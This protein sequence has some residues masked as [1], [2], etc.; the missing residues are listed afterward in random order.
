[1]D[2]MKFMVQGSEE[3]PYLVT[4]EREETN[5][6][7]YCTCAAGARGQYCKHRFR[8][9]SGNPEDLIEPDFPRLRL[10]VD[11]LAGT[12]IEAA[13]RVLAKAEDSFEK[14]KAD[15]AKAKKSLAEAMRR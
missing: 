15:L 14:A 2:Q 1:M 9:L 11:W 5:L 8:I 7:A 10:A 3:E 6:N 12:D 13:I 4:L